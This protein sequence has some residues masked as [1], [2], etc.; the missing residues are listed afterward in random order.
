MDN[1]TGSQKYFVD[2][3]LGI[4]GQYAALQLADMARTHRAWIEVHEEGRKTKISQDAIARE[5]HDIL[6]H[7]PS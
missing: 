4:Y 3:I 6:L 1:L 2:I 7:T 5:F